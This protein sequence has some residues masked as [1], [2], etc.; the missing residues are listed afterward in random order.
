MNAHPLFC[1]ASTVFSCLPSSCNLSWRLCL[2]LLYYLKLCSVVSWKREKNSKIVT[3]CWLHI[4]WAICLL[5][6]GP[7]PYHA[8]IVII[9][10]LTSGQFD[11][12]LALISCAAVF[13]FRRRAPLW[14]Y[15]AR[16]RQEVLPVRRAD[17]PLPHAHGRE[18]LQLPTVRQVLH[19]ERP[20][21]QTCPT[22][23]WLP[24]KHAAGLQRRQ[25]TPLLLVGVVFR[26]WGQEPCRGVRHNLWL[27]I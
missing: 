9:I 20:P 12:Q 26:L 19:E 3:N 8:I 24:A 13:F 23:R 11:L 10:I 1:N 17:P 25:E 16:L 22:T 14:V 21:D 15:L 6:W 2:Q 27:Y 18:A 7:W 5:Q 4:N